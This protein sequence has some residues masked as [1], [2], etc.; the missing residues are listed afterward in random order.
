MIVGD[1]RSCFFETP[2]LNVPIYA[3]ANDLEHHM[4]NKEL[5]KNYDEIVGGP[6]VADT[7]DL[8]QRIL[9]INQ[10]DFTKQHKVVENYLN[11]CDGKSAKRLVDM[12]F[13]K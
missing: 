12:L 3:T 8:I 2:L 13:K 7:M 5:N 6:I 10:Y 9:E 4:E 1:Y 11:K